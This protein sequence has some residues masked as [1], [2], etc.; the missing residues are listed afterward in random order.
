MVLM[1]A[2]WGGLPP[3]PSLPWPSFFS[4]SFCPLLLFVEEITM[5]LAKVATTLYLSMM[6][7]QNSRGCCMPLNRSAWVHHFA[8]SSCGHFS[9]MGNKFFICRTTGSIPA[10]LGMSK[11]QMRRSKYSSRAR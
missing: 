9:Y 6:Y 10:S 8:Y 4:L 3:P 5:W 2:F 11:V 7:R 1:L